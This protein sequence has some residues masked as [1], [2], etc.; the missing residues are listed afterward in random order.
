MYLLFMK[1]TKMLHKQLN[2]HMLAWSSMH[3]QPQMSEWHKQKCWSCNPLIFP[4]FATSL[5]YIS[6][7]RQ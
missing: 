7:S 3:M 4:D 6:A 2:G 5:I 1:T